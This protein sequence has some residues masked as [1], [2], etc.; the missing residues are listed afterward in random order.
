[1]HTIFEAQKESWFT[2]INGLKRSI[3]LVYIV[4]VK[5]FHA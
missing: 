1:M 2:Q 3:E 4:F 5:V